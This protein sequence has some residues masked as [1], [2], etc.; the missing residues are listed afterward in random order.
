MPS[1][2]E[3]K[4]PVC[5]VENAPCI[6][7]N[8]IPKYHVERKRAA[9][10]TRYEHPECEECRKL[11]DAMVYAQDSYNSFRPEFGASRPKSRWPKAY[12]EESY[13]QELSAN[14]TK[15]EYEFH[16]ATVHKDEL[17]Q[18]SI[19]RNLEII[20]RKGRLKP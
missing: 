7:E 11:K 6:T 10:P 15:A 1:V 13:R 5:G 18:S 14:R 3:I 20:I 9:Y 17:Y 8:G 19:Q 12:R 2:H 16:L 4:C